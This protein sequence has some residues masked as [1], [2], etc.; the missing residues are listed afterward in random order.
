M[1]SALMILLMPMKHLVIANIIDFGYSHSRDRRD[2]MWWVG[3]I[4][5]VLTETLLTIYLI[6]DSGSW[7]VKN[8]PVIE[9]IWFFCS[10]YRERTALLGRELRTHFF[11]EGLLLTMYM[12]L[13]LTY[14]A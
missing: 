9:F 7:F 2:P 4:Q 5:W 3:F 10:T 14:F 8:F 1:T 11:W 6:P 13:I 12:S